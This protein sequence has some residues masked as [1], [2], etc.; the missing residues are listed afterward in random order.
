MK[1][2]ATLR[3]VAPAKPSDICFEGE[4]VVWQ[5]TLDQI[6]SGTGAILHRNL[7]PASEAGNSTHPFDEG[8]VL[9]SKLRP[10]L[11]KVVCPNEP[12]I[13]T[14]ELVPL[15]PDPK[16]LDRRY[17]CY[18]LRSPRFVAWATQRVSG[19]KMPRVKMG[20]FWEHEIPLPP[21]AQQQRIAGLLDTASA[22]WEKRARSERLLGDLPPSIFHDMFGS[23]AATTS[24]WP[25]VELGDVCIS[26]ETTDPTKTPNLEFTYI[27][28]AS[29]DTAE[30]RVESPQTLLGEDAPSRARQM[31]LA[32][33]VLVSSV[34]PNLRQT[35]MVPKEH[36]GQ[37]CSTGFAVLRAAPD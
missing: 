34:R 23:V 9:Y 37:V 28:I 17:L 18:Y 35:A 3:E 7:A 19:A 32:G 11:N 31:V 24:K 12:G 29:I 27:D 21:L 16:R 26:I 22:L 36:D 8:N 14:T 6:E 30:G 15:R 33:D 4:A 20:L 13:S 25:S 5:L 2:V 1:N 10:N